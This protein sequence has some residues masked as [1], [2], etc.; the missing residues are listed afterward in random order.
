MSLRCGD[1]VRFWAIAL[2]LAGAGSAGCQP[3]SSRLTRMHMADDQRE[4]AR[5]RWD[6]MRGGARLQLAEKHLRAGRLHP[7]LNELLAAFEIA[8]DHPRVHLG[9]AR[10]Y[11][12][13]GELAKAREAAE[14][15]R[16]L[17]GDAEADYVAGIVSQR[18]GDHGAALVRYEAAMRKAP[19]APEHVLAVAET[20]VALR[21]PADA[22][23]IV[24]ARRADFEGNS[25]V[26]LLASQ[27][28]RS[29]GLREPAVEHAAEAAR[30]AADDPGTLVEYGLTLAWAERHEEAIKVLRPRFDAGLGATKDKDEQAA[31]AEAAAG[32]APSAELP[33]SAVNVLVRCYL[34]M[35]RPGDALDVLRRAPDGPIDAGRTA[36]AAQALLMNNDP[37]TA[38][39]FIQTME[40][41]GELTGEVCLLGAYAAIRCD[42]LDAA[43]H[44]ATR[45]LS[46]P[47]CTWA[48]HCLLGQVAEARGKVAEAFEAYRQGA[49][50]EDTSALARGLLRRLTAQSRIPSAPTRD[51]PVAQGVSETPAGPEPE[52]VAGPATGVNGAARVEADGRAAEEAPT[53]HERPSTPQPIPPAAML[54]SVG[55]RGPY[56]GSV[57]P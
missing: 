55:E 32:G 7:A 54:G 48:A 44:F 12:E 27:I 40:Q 11:L 10:V 13:L 43:D 21:R 14:R 28:E 16:A 45:A 36:L 31:P 49:A 33:P 2:T 57:A 24:S 53:V 25:A 4:D 29:L 19:H 23:G 42:T 37:A 56:G 20:L 46:D 6:A 30:L 1:C 35:N 22:L 18:Y 39:R 34:A 17:A 26:W 8:P 41:Q 38:L 52:I 51:D 3:P 47:A 15:A 5:K 9:L 50:D